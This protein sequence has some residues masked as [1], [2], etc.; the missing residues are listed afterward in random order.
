MEGAKV[1][2]AFAKGGNRGGEVFRELVASSIGK[3][4]NLQIFAG[5]G[6]QGA[7]LLAGR[8]IMQTLRCKML[9]G[10]EID[11]SDHKVVVAEV[12]GILTAP[13]QS[14]G[15]QKEQMG[16]L[17]GD[18]GFRAPGPALDPSVPPADSSKPIV[19]DSSGDSAAIQRTMG[20][21]VRR[22]DENM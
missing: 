12:L 22:G 19:E 11:V 6:T 5:E 15:S 20:L 14:S 17:Y 10:K 2:E 4:G 8:G 7:P 16:L 3:E 18:R 9:P 21:N 13:G 1:G